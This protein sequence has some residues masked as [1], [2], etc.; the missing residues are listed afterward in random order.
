MPPFHRTLGAL[1][2]NDGNTRAGFSAGLLSGGDI[3]ELTARGDVP[4]SASLAK[5]GAPNGITSDSLDSTTFRKGSMKHWHPW[6]I[7]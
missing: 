5:S 3:R 1:G 4:V 2:V 6:V 7:A